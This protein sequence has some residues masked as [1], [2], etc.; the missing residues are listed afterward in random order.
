MQLECISIIKSN[1][2]FYEDAEFNNIQESILWDLLK[3]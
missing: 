1:T 2:K 3:S